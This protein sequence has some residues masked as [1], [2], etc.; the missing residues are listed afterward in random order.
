[1]S[2][3]GWPRGRGRPLTPS[4]AGTQVFFLG[5][6]TTYPE[7]LRD[8]GLGRGDCFSGL[9]SN[10]VSAGRCFIRSRSP[11][12]KLLTTPVV[13]ETYE[14][15]KPTCTHTLPSSLPASAHQCL[16]RNLLISFILSPCREDTFLE[17][18]DFH[19]L[20]SLSGSTALAQRRCS[21][22]MGRHNLSDELTPGRKP[23]GRGLGAEGGHVGRITALPEMSPGQAGCYV[24]IVSLPGI[25]GCMWKGNIYWVDVSVTTISN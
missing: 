6:L 10:L 24:H 4:P 12:W 11:A 14:P 13:Q 21:I 17:E 19:W 8:E 20:C 18:T 16:Q 7:M 15:L 25:T 9:R 2:R 1:M 3:S 5:L 23:A 22:K